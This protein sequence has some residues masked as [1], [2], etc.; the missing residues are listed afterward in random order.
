MTTKKS[1]KPKT[2]DDNRSA[3]DQAGAKAP[4]KSPRTA[5]PAKS[6][7]AAGESAKPR[8]A[9]SQARAAAGSR[10]QVLMAVSRAAIDTAEG[11]RAALI[12]A[13][14]L[15]TCNLAEMNAAR[16]AAAASSEFVALVAAHILAIE[17]ITG[18]QAVLQGED[19]V[20]SSAPVVVYRVMVRSQD[21]AHVRSARATVD[22]SSETVLEVG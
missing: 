14:P 16:N 1:S 13:S 3:G 9:R 12:A 15:Q 4:R 20:Q 22:T 2:A 10:P 18:Q 7:S 17:S 19:C 5:A 6:K 11:M 8:V 21:H